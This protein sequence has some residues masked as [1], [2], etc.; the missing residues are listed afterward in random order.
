MLHGEIGED[1]QKVEFVS[2]DGKV[3]LI[4]ASREQC[5]KIE[6]CLTDDVINYIKNARSKC[7]AK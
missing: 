5:Q 7:L 6:K 2:Y 4:K 1:L 3:I